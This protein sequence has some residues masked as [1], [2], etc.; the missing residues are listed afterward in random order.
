MGEDRQAGQPAS[1]RPG[2]RPAACGRRERRKKRAP[3][4]GH[5]SLRLLDRLQ[6][7]ASA[8][9]ARP[10]SA[11]PEPRNENRRNPMASLTIPSAGPAACFRRRQRDRLSSV[12][13]LARMRPGQ[14]AFGALAG[15]SGAGGR[16]SCARRR[17]S[18]PTATRTSRPRFPGSAA[19]VPVAHPLSASARSGEPSAPGIES[20]SATSSPRSFAQGPARLPRTS[21]LP[22]APAAPVPAHRRAVRI[23]RAGPLLRPRPF[24]RRLGPLPLAPPAPLVPR[25]RLAPALRALRRRPRLRPALQFRAGLARLRRQRLAP[26]RL[27]R[28]ALRIRGVPDIRA[29]RLA[30]QVPGPAAQPLA[31]RHRPVAPNAVALARVRPKLRA[32]HA[33]RAD[34]RQPQLPRHRQHLQERFA[35]RLG[36]PPPKRADRVVVRVA[37]RRHIADAQVPAG[38][39]PGPARAGHPVGVAASRQRRRHPRVVPR[40]PRAPLVRL[41]RARRNP[42]HRLQD[43]MRQI[44]FRHPIAD[45]RGKQVQ[46]GGV[47]PGKLPHPGYLGPLAQRPLQAIDVQVRQ[48]ARCDLS[49]GCS[50]EPDA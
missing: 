37:A 7:Q 31:Q 40:R 32:V 15:L 18:D 43:E 20:T 26:P 24:P 10:A 2:C 41:E 25:R 5:A 27:L 44:V 6:L 42:L 14:S 11:F 17:S 46:L 45:V 16:K 23:R 47:A 21:W 30:Q 28:Q 19:S 36:V 22:P 29:L 33:R 34:L 1:R 48:A 9:K 38:R 8:A 4:P 39:P 12:A 3:R 35:R 13:V 49:V 50:S